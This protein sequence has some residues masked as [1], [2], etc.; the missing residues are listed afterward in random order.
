MQGL[1]A[2]GEGVTTGLLYASFGAM[3]APVVVYGSPYLLNGLNMADRVTGGALTRSGIDIFSQSVVNMGTKGLKG[4]RELD[5]AD[6]IISATGINYVSG[7]VIG[8]AVDW[9]PFGNVNQISIIGYGKNRAHFAT[10]F[11][12]GLISGGQSKI[13]N[14]SGANKAVVNIFNIWNTTKTNALGEVVKNNIE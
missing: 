9:R 4:L 14:S 12:V 11:S 1:N 10:D 13:L 3:A 7:A 2:I 5:V 6:V 8:A